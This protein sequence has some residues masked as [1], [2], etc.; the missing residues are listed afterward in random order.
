MSNRMLW[1][2]LTRRKQLFCK[3]WW[4]RSQGSCCFEACGCRFWMVEDSRCCTASLESNRSISCFRCSLVQNKVA[5]STSSF[6]QMKK[7][8]ASVSPH[9][10]TCVSHPV[11]RNQHRGLHA[12]GG[13][14]DFTHNASREK[15]SATDFEHSLCVGVMCWPPHYVG[16]I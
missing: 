8:D 3:T 7:M 5:V 10:K 12:N 4:L 13:M 6:R 1:V 11:I 15:S 9:S 14:G 2:E 16:T